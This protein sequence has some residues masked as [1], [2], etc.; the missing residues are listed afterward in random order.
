MALYNEILSEFQKHGAELVGISVDGVCT[1]PWQ[2]TS[3]RKAKSPGLTEPIGPKKAS[4]SGHSLSS[5][6][7]ASLPGAISPRSPSIP[8]P[9]VFCRLLR[10]YL[11][12][13]CL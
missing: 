13:R 11:N 6:A 12:R 3:S 1:F 8:E 4:A 9:K 2:P 7:T 5:T 10:G